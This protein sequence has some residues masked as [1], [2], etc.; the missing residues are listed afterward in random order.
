MHGSDRSPF[1]RE[2]GEE[3]D[4]VIPHEGEEDAPGLQA[5]HVSITSG[6]RSFEL[7]EPVPFVAPFVR[8]VS[9]GPPALLISQHLTVQSAPPLTST[10]D[11]ALN[12]SE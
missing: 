4:S 9:G 12:A 7:C 2:R 6:P 8:V 3:I 10:L 5:T 1:G 11:S